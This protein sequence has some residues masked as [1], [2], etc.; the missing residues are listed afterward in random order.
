VMGIFLFATMST[1]ALG[2]T[3]PHIQWVLRGLNERVKQSGCEAD[4]SHPSSAKD[5]LHGII[6]PL[7]QYVFMEWC[8]IK[9]EIYLHGVISYTQE[10]LY[11]YLYVPL[12]F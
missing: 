7:L 3:W 12:E 5:K 11:L 10:Q 9:H 1:L 2:P 4:H 6:L 8:L